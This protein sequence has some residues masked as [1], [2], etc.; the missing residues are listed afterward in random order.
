MVISEGYSPF[1]AERYHI[2]LPNKA[3]DEEKE[4]GK[5]AKKK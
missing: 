1:T 4:K 3:A 5:H 2:H